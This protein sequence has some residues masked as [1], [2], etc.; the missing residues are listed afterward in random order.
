MSP[1]EKKDLKKARR[2]KK[3]RAYASVSRS[4]QP[5]A[6]KKPLAGKKPRTGKKLCALK[7]NPGVDDF[8]REQQEWTVLTEF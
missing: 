7:M 6:G 4:K 8:A 5:R 2:R 1:E 3:N